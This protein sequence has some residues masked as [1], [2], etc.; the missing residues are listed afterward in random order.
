MMKKMFSVFL[1]FIMMLSC[2]VT[3][4]AQN[5]NAQLYT[6]YGDGMLFQHSKEAVIA[7]KASD[8]SKISATLYKN[9]EIVS[10]GETVAADGVF[11]VSF[12][13]PVGGY[14]EYTVVLECDGYVFEQ[15]E[16]VVFGELWIA[17]GQS[18]MQYS[19]SQE[20]TGSAMFEK[21]EP[22]GEWLRV[23]CVPAI[24]EYKGSTQLVPAQPQNDIPGAV[25]T[26]GN[27]MFVYNMSAVAYFFA[28]DLHD[29]LDMPVGVLNIPLGGSVISSWLGR[30][31]ID[32]DEEVK[33]LLL[34]LGEYYNEND[35]NES[36][37]SAYYDMASNYNLK[38]EALRHFRVSG[39][40]WYQGESD[41]IYGKTPE[42]YEKM[43]DLMQKSYTEVF[44]YD[45]GLMP[46]IYTQ[47]A[48]YKYHLDNGI[49]LV[50]MNAHYAKMQQ[51][52]P[53]S[54]AAVAI[55]D[56]PLSFIP[57]AGS[58]HPDIKKEIGERMA[59][60]AIGLVY[61]GDKVFT[62]SYIKNYEISDGR[63]Y[64]TL[65]NVGDGLVFDGEIGS[66][67]AVAGADGV[68]VG[69]DA[70]IIDA[71]TIAIYNE[72]VEEPVSASY[73]YSLGNINS[74]LYASENGEPVFP[75]SPFVTTETENTFYW[76]EKAWA[77]CE[78][79][80]SWHVKNDT[81]TK[82]YSVW[83]AENAEIE[84]TAESAFDGAKGL[85]VKATSENF[86]VNP[87][88][89]HEDGQKKVWIYDEGYD[90][91]RYGKIIFRVRNDGENDVVA[92]GVKLYTSSAS[93][94]S[95]AGESVVIPADG[96]WHT[97]ETDIDHLYIYGID[98][99]VKLSNDRPG[100][101][102]GLEFM[103]SGKDAVISVDSFEFAPES[104]DRD[105]SFDFTKIFN[106]INVVKMFFEN[107][108]TLI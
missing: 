9:G 86:S 6:F 83:E 18:N 1:V 97:I 58:I 96:E 60:S 103:F 2:I 92:E 3:T 4:S 105:T 69:A 91:S 68:F 7:G 29:E 8:G 52:Q 75:V 28:K 48:S 24:P 20:K 66:G 63:I 10:S 57:S 79:E 73:A 15:L 42:Q 67:F 64:V 76:S 51:A 35:W 77:D 108:L 37:R 99:G 47:L 62:A 59:K 11:A 14:S 78:Y 12:D 88:L 107:L 74:N 41:V 50:E 27:D 38:V 89:V 19:L 17:S 22:L 13:S 81:Y 40:I 87:L 102:A 82:E 49:D 95:S 46:V 25:W 33:N 94:Y 43:F 70:E 85:S 90:Y 36:E 31:A 5:G 56:I 39:M 84:F 72:N 32:G 54:R 100:D 55:Y 26:T 16:N 30:D 44:E 53:E 93:W 65:D 34:S 61:G 98:F 71:D 45:D 21:N 23:L 101:V 80:T 106:I 104:G